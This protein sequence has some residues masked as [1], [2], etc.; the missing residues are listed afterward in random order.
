M[1]KCY[2]QFLD[3]QE[4]QKRL[5]GVRIKTLILIETF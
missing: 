1:L 2:K 5:E 4:Q 3:Q